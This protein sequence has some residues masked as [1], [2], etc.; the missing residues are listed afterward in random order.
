MTPGARIKAVIDL[1]DC[2]ESDGAPAD[3]LISTYFRSRRYA[4]SK[5]RKTITGQVYDIL[6]GRAALDWWVVQIR[7]E[8]PVTSRQRMLAAL[9]IINDETV[10][11]VKAL[12]EVGGTYGPAP[13]D[14]AESALVEALSGK[15]LLDPAQPPDVRANY[16]AWL[17][18]SLSRVFGERLE[19]EMSALNT[20]APLDLRVNMLKPSADHMKDVLAAQGVET[21]PTTIS[22]WGLRSL[23]HQRIDHLKA[24]QDGL[25]EVQDEG[26]QIIALLVGAKPG[27]RVVDYCAGGGGKTLA[28]SAAM[29]NKGYIFACDTSEKRLS[30]LPPRLK[31][32]RAHNVEL[33]VLAEKDDLWEQAHEGEFDRVLVDAPCSGMGAW[34]RNPGARWRLLRQDIE[35]HA[36]RQGAILERVAGLVRTGGRLVYATCSLLMEE[37]EDVIAG[38]L[39]AHPDFSIVPASKVWAETLGA[40]K[41][42]GACPDDGEFL[43]LTPAQNGTDGFF[44]AILERRG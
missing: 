43:H 13:L 21:T 22:P 34:R 8:G 9:L 10:E 4:G 6:R 12:F 29:E 2:M 28:L 19:T 35:H 44:A 1:L 25:V 20:R 31:R 3:R 26:S 18:P 27:M 23:G 14:E 15:A 42:A 5:D 32:A 24:M 37:N 38:F 17:N 36:I 39:K 16:P 7:G 11:A 30:G 40:I 33:Q 41:G